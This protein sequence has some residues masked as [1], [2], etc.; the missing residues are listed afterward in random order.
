MLPEAKRTSIVKADIACGILACAAKGE[1]DADGSEN[2]GPFCR[3]GLHALFALH[4]GG[5]MGGLSK[6]EPRWCT[7]QTWWGCG[8]GDA[9]TSTPTGLAKP[10]RDRKGDIAST[11]RTTSIKSMQMGVIAQELNSA[12]RGISCSLFNPGR[13]VAT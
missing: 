12:R 11:R 6:R 3:R 1:R 8:Y 2:S 13:P 4:L 5:S 10:G 7:W 9:R